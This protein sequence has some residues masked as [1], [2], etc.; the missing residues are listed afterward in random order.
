[1]PL[2]LIGTKLG[3]TRVFTEAGAARAVTVIHVPPN[4]VSQTKNMNSDGYCALQ[5]A[6]AKRKPSAINKPLAGHAKKAGISPGRHIRE[7]R[8]KEEERCPLGSELHVGLFSVGQKVKVSAKSKGKGFAGTVKRHNF[9]MQDATH[10]NSLSHRA[11][12]SIGQ[13]Q[14]PGRVFK[15]KK[16]AGQMGNKRVT[17]RNLEIVRVDKDRQLLLIEGAVPGHPGCE[18]AVSHLGV[19]PYEGGQTEEAEGEVAERPAGSDDTAA[20]GERKIHA[21]TSEDGGNQR[22]KT[23]AEPKRES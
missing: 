10:G 21:A 14:L 5:I 12:G 16:M 8:I 18:V 6:A 4:R 11:P 1:M 7:F 15:G 17:I 2:G 23:A 13:C 20:N 22:G 19:V 9:S 3:M